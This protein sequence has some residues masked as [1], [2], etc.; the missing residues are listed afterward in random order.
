MIFSYISFPLFLI[1]L[2]IGLFFVYIL[3]PEQKII[4][5]YP[6]PDNVQTVQYKDNIDQCFSYQSKETDCPM[7][8]FLV[9]TIPVQADLKPIE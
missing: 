4:Y 1:S 2:A 6:T 8:P 9:H 3:G 7:N 5:V